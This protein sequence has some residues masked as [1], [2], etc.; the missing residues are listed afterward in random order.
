MP[1]KRREILR[2]ALGVGFLSRLFAV[3]QESEQ[4]G[5][6]AGVVLVASFELLAGQLDQLRLERLV[7]GEPLLAFVLGALAV[8]GVGQEIDTLGGQRLA[9]VAV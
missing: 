8:A 6:L 2:R 7:L 1:L 5:G 9:G 3:D 4:L